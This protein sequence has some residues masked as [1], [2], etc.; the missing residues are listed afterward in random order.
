MPIDG[1]SMDDSE[2]TV[3]VESTMIS[4]SI[5]DEGGGEDAIKG[6]EDIADSRE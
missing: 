4:L 5:W 3:C 1:D 6:G 2:R